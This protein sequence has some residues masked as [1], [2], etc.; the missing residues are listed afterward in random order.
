LYNGKCLNYNK[1]CRFDDVM[2]WHLE[3]NYGHERRT[4]KKI[5]IYIDHSS[6]AKLLSLKQCVNFFISSKNRTIQVDEHDLI[7]IHFKFIQR[8]E[9][10]TNITLSKSLVE[11]MWSITSVTLIYNYF[12]SH[13]FFGFIYEYHLWFSWEHPR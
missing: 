3:K 12:L 1:L 11:R 5:K 4:Y 10:D 13:F 9:G 7:A 6:H 8:I 2:L